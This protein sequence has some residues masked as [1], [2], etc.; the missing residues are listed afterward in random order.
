MWSRIYRRA[1]FNPVMNVKAQKI[2]IYIKSALSFAMA[3]ITSWSPQKVM[4]GE[5]VWLMEVV[6][7][8]A[9]IEINFETQYGSY[10][11]FLISFHQIQPVLNS[12]SQFGIYHWN[13]M[14]MTNTIIDINLSNKGRPKFG[15]CFVFFNCPGSL[16]AE[17]MPFHDTIFLLIM[18]PLCL[19]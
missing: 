4:D 17:D 10:L 1:S 9:R 12:G 3:Q 7:Q 6:I 11:S 16:V 5:E 14:T 8:R 18:W 2:G 15:S 13:W 19:Y